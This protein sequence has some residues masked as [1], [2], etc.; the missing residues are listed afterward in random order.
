MRHLPA[1]LLSV[2]SAA[3]E[4]IGVAAYAFV[5]SFA[6]QNLGWLY[7]FGFSVWPVVLLGPVIYLLSRYRR[8]LNQFIFYLSAGLVAA[9]AGSTT[10]SYVSQ[11]GFLL[12]SPGLPIGGTNGVTVALSS[13]VLLAIVVTVA[14]LRRNE[15]EVNDVGRR[16]YPAAAWKTLVAA[17][18]LSEAFV[19]GAFA[20]GCGGIIWGLYGI[21]FS[22]ALL[23]FT[24]IREATLCGAVTIFLAGGLIPR[25][26]KANQKITVILCVGA[27]VVSA[28]IGFL[29][30]PPQ[31]IPCRPV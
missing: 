26:I 27:A 11:N 8:P 31:E 2:G 18:A 17:F 21:M 19:F 23:H 10:A 1:N 12:G 16:F 14:S 25:L 6:L 22:P 3:R 20:N 29:V 4:V 15:A 28:M 13:A 5:I 30:T 9:L 24:M 7:W